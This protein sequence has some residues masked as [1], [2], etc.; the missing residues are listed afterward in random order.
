MLSSLM[1]PSFE[2]NNILFGYLEEQ[3]QPMVWLGWKCGKS[4]VRSWE[5][6]ADILLGAGGGSL[7][8]L[9]DEVKMA[10]SVWRP[11]MLFSHQWQ[12]SVHHLSPLSLPPSRSPLPL[13]LF[14]STWV[15][16]LYPSFSEALPCKRDGRLA[17]LWNRKLTVPT[18]WPQWV[19]RTWD[20]R[21]SH[22]FSSMSLVHYRK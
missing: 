15:C 10:S 21:Q 1:H 19:P 7:L 6:A 3:W 20:H 16:S 4:E 22:K 12:L 13:I 2:K 11:S 9:A 18:G 8:E 17:D 14:L 5:R